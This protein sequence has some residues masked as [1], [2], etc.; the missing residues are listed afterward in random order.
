MKPTICL[1][2]P[3]LAVVS[4]QSNGENPQA[5]EQD[6]PAGETAERPIDLDKPETLIGRRLEKVQAACTTAEVPHRVV[7]VDGESRPVTMDYRPERLNFKVKGG[8][9]IEVTNG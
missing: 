5:V 8:R 7:E 3:L 2:V 6:P 4:C 9:I 1:L